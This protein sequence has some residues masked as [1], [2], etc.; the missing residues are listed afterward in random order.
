MNS[1]LEF[2]KPVIELEEKIS[3]LES[4]AESNNVDLSDEIDI[5]KKKLDKIKSEIY[6]SLTPWQIVKISRL[7]ER[8]TTLEYINLI[9]PDFIE[10]HGDR[11]YGDDSAIVGGIGTLEGIPVTVIGHQKGKNTKENI[12]RNFGMPHPEGYR[13][14]LRLMKQAE[15]FKRPVIMFIDTPGAYCGLGAEE[16]GQGEAIAVNLLE[17]SRL[18]TPIIIVVIGEGGSG[19]ALALG[20]GDRVYM[21]QNSIYSVISP[22]G[23]SSILWKD[24]SLAEKAADIMKLTAKDLLK[25]DVIDKI[26]EEPLGGAHK[27][28]DFISKNIK[29]YLLAEIPSLIELDRD[30]LL[31]SRYKKIRDIG[32]WE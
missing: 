30:E 8:P 3:E 5:L 23:L 20:I 4:F 17:M 13:K 1:T 16:R 9:I 7:Q 19:G 27:D 2:E 32:L 6:M 29:E 12:Q 14:A 18:K 31:N 26:I 11:F 10:L 28:I 15:K 22:E 24:V 21:L 25:L